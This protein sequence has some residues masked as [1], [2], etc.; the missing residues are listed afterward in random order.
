MY[1]HLACVYFCVLGRLVMS[2]HIGQV[3]LFMRYPMDLETYSFMLTR[4]ICSRGTPYMGSVGL[5]VVVG[6][7]KVSMLVGGV[8]P[9]QLAVSLCLMLCF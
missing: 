8:N 5:S 3:A 4:V 6:I 1:F 9:S 2:P 7:T